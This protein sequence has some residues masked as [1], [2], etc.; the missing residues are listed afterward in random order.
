MVKLT[1]NVSSRQGREQ[2]IRVKLFEKQGQVWAEP[3]ESETAQVSNLTRADGVI[4]VP[5]N[6]EGLSSGELAEFY[7]LW[8]GW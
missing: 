8:F 4:R 2:F 3:L 6:V 1:R 7:P 5:S